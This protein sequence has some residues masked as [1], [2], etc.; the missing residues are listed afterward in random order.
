MNRRQF[1]VLLLVTAAA[2]ALT[3]GAQAETLLMPMVDGKLWTPPP[4][5]DAARRRPNI[6]PMPPP[7]TLPFR[8]TSSRVDVRIDENIATTSM[9]QSFLNMSGRDL[10]VRVLIPLPSGAS[11]NSSALSMN[12]EM[13]EGKIYDAQQAQSIYESIVSQRRDPALL[14]FSGE[15]LYEAR[16]FPI[17]PNQERKLKFSYTQVL[18]ASAGM[19]DYRHILS[20][21]QLY[22]KGIEKFAFECVIRSKTPLGPIYSP[23][24]QVA[25]TRPDDKTASIKLSGVNMSSDR[26]FRL[27]YAPS[28]NDVAMRVIAHRNSDT[29]EGYFMLIARADDQLQKTRVITK[30]VVFVADTSGSMRGEKI[31]QTQSALK[32]CIDSLAD[33]DRFNLITF[34]T[35][36]QALSPNKLLPATKENKAKA[37]RAIDQIEASG[38]TN[39]DGAMQAALGSDF[40]DSADCARM[41]VFMT[42]G[43]PTVGVT[44]AAAILKDVETGNQKHKARIFNFGVGNDVNTHLLDKVALNFDGVST[45]VSPREDIEVKVSDFYSKIKHP[46]M[47]QVSFDFGTD[48]GVNSVYPKRIPALYRGSELMLLGR[49]KGKGPGQ[50]TLTGNVGGEQRSIS[51]KVEWPSRDLD[52]SYLPRVWAMR[53]IGHLLED[54]RLFGQNQ[55]MI[56]EVVELAQRHGIVTPYTSQLVLEPGMRPGTDGVGGWGGGAGRGIPNAPMSAAEALG[57]QDASKKNAEAGAFSAGRNA[58]EARSGDMATSLADFERTMKTAIAAPVESA[59]ASNEQKKEKAEKRRRLAEGMMAD[60][61]MGVNAKNLDEAGEAIEQAEA[62]LIKNVGARTFYLRGGIWV[63]ATAKANAKLTNLKLFSK[64]YFEMLK[65]DSTLGPVLALGNRIIVVVKDT[66]YQIEE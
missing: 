35:D 60:G 13:V 25:V 32:F 62:Q 61:K 58:R 4:D 11:I 55:E 24:H 47:T 28:A 37:V 57:R 59:F 40:S 36:V 5:N 9:E 42:D 44:D 22:E 16:V 50:I 27:Y 1:H 10:E 56:R 6:A 7:M 2:L 52:N 29:D 18:N 46:V 41:I 21:S 49:F 14:R 38:G 33:G 45:Y 54:L 63:D 39:I 3:H 51:L 12:D 19:Y 64:E 31:K 30:E 48:S 15:N 53:K 65:T 23:S 8:V 34:A 43:L 20:G 66:T 17:P 26:D